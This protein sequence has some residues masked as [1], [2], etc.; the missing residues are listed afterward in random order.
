M[1]ESIIN[2]SVNLRKKE[3]KRMKFYY[4]LERKLGKYAIPH[5][6]TYIIGCYIIGYVLLLSAPALL[7]YLTLEPYLVLRGQIWRLFTWVLVPSSGFSIIF[8]AI[9][10]LFYYQLGTQLEYYWGTFKFNLYMF[11]GLIFTNIAAFILYGISCSIAG[12]SISTKFS[13]I[14]RWIIQHILY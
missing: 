13:G 4:K 9:M 7:N 6:M 11:E 8:T 3:R 12:T 14:C 1:W 2:T 10:L 5:L